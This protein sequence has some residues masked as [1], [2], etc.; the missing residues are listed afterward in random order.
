MVN[1]REVI[2]MDGVRKGAGRCLGY[3]C[4]NRLELIIFTY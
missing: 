1:E 3:I 2:R 4:H